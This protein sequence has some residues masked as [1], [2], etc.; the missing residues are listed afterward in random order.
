MKISSS[1]EKLILNPTESGT[2]REKKTHSVPHCSIQIHSMCWKF[3]KSMHLLRNVLKWQGTIESSE[4]EGLFSTFVSFTCKEIG[5]YRFHEIFVTIGHWRNTTVTSIIFKHTTYSNIVLYSDSHGHLFSKLE[6]D[7]T[8][9]ICSGVIF[10]C[11]FWDKLY[12]LFT[13]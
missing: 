11:Y 7:V 1:E 8:Q 3:H 9:R 13:L 5:Y 4:F 6:V 2:P 10:S 12:L